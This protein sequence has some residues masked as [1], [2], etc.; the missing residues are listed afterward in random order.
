MAE[1]QAASDGSDRI[2]S[3]PAHARLLQERL[4]GSGK[5]GLVRA[6][7]PVGGGCYLEGYC[8]NIFIIAFSMISS[9]FSCWSGSIF[10]WATPRHLSFFAERSTTSITNVPL[11]I[12]TA[13]LPCPMAPG[14]PSSHQ[15]PSRPGMA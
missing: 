3:R 15:G 6:K 14:S 2:A 5:I 11:S 1:D 8:L 7:G 4:P 12:N 10:A 13:A 9:D